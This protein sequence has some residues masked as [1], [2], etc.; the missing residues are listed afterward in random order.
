[1]SM[2]PRKPYDPLADHLPRGRTTGSACLP[3]SMPRK[4]YDPLA[5]HLARGR[6]DMAQFRAGREFQ[7]HIEVADKMRPADLEREQPGNLDAD[8]DAAWKWLAKCYR[9]LGADGSA[10]TNDV[11]IDGKTTKQI[12]ESRSR[13]GADWERY[14]ARRLF[15]CLGTLATVYGFASEE[16]KIRVPGAKPQIIGVQ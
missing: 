12:A 3:M 7:G 5:D 6:I 14:Y 1:M 13:T 15:E 10:L 9:A 4:P 11:L 2:Q 16:K 8:Q